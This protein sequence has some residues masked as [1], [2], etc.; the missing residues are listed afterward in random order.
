MTGRII[1]LLEEPS[2]KAL[3]ESLLPRVF[4]GWAPGSHFLC[5]RHQGKD[6]LRKSIPRKLRA[7]QGISDRFVVV[8]DQDSSDCVLLKQNLTGLCTDAG[9]PQC[10]VRVVCRELESWYLGDLDALS[11]E[12]DEA[13]LRH[14]D[15]RR[16]FR[17]P[18]SIDKPARILEKL[19]PGFQKISGARRMGERLTPE[20]NK[21]KSFAT[22]ISGVRQVA[23]EMGYSMP[24]N[25]N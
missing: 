22:F 20:S 7:W 10:L 19:L 4:P 16:R 15:S 21:S 13:S 2:M 25:P 1:F 8:Q 14:K 17:D 23:S 9:H 3:L 12:F 18:D 6:D 24:Q 11:K 5:I